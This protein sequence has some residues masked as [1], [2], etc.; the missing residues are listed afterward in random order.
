MNEV[1]A[2]RDRAN[3]EGGGDIR[4]ARTQVSHVEE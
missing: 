2:G 3:G 4:R 1:D